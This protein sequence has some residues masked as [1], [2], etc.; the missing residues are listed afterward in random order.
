M[1]K[2]IV[3]IVESFSTGIFSY[4]VD[5][6][7]NLKDK[8]DF[9]ILYGVRKE[10]PNDVEKHFNKN[11]D[12]IKIE[13]F[14]RNIGLKD[15]KAIKEIKRILKN[16]RHDIIHLHSSKAGMLR[17][18]IHEKNMFYTPHGYAFLTNKKL[19]RIIYKLG[20]VV[21]SKINKNT[22]TIAC[23][24]SEY[25]E[26]I[27]FNKNSIYINNGIDIKNI[28]T[29]KKNNP[30]ISICTSGRIEMQKNPSLFNEIAL[31]FPNINFTWIGDGSLRNTLTSTNIKVTGMKEKEDVYNLLLE[32]DIFIFTSLWEGLSISLLEAMYLEKICIVSNI[33]SNKEV[34]KNNI[35]GFIAETLDDY[36]KIIEKII[37]NKVNCEK[38]KRQAK[39]TIVNNYNIEKMCK[40]YEKAYK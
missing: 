5:I 22:K 28:K 36:I 16:E 35:N 34:V 32:N 37:N 13:S 9:L 40:E 23:S 4:M 2:R 11:V 12:L 17:M 30:N 39:K 10:T 7:N 29:K 24:K 33:S 14:Q 27:K 20:E 3:Y 15:I 18:A 25:L 26:T 19:K 8:Y 31:A 38:I 6:T 1:K 21:L